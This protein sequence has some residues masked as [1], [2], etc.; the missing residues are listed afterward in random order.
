ASLD[1]CL[2]ANAARRVEKKFVVGGHFWKASKALMPCIGTMYLDVAR[3]RL[4]CAIPVALSVGSPALPKRQRTGAL[5]NLAEVPV[6]VANAPASWS[7][8]ALRRF[9]RE[10][11]RGIRTVQVRTLCTARRRT[12]SSLQVDWLPPRVAIRF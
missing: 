2:A 12:S 11:A 10:R 3:Q 4:G 7:A 9:R 5:Q 1:A 6:T 8:A